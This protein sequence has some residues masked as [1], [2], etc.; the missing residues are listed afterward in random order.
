VCLVGE[1]QAALSWSEEVFVVMSLVEGHHLSGYQP[2]PAE[3]FDQE[4]WVS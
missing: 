1:V 4:H 2:R 3:R